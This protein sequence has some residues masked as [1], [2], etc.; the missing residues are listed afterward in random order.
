M[1]GWSWRTSP[2]RR[3][4]FLLLFYYIEK[5]DGQCQ[6]KPNIKYFPSP[7]DEHHGFGVGSLC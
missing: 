1:D 3:S 2:R 4:L 5:D 6:F 7:C